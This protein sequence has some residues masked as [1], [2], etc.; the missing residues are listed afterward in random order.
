[1]NLLKIKNRKGDKYFFYY[2][3][4]RGKG[5]RPATGVFIYVKPKDQ[6]EKNHNKEALAL[7]ETKKS[8]LI[9]E[10]QAVGTGHILQHK[11][12]QNFVDFFEE[13][14]RLNRREKNRS[15]PCCLTA[16]NKFLRKEKELKENEHIYLSTIDITENFCERFRQH[17]LDNL[18]G[19]TPGDYFMRF[20]RVMKAAFK[21][22]YFKVNPA[23]EVKTKQHPSGIKDVLT[24]DEYLILIN[25][26]CSNHE[27]KKAAVCSLY[28]GFR[29]CDVGILQWWQIKEETII[30]RKQN[31][32]GV[33]LEVPLP[34]VV[35][36]I[37][38]E[39]K[40]PNDLVFSLPTQDGANKVLKEWVKSAGINKHITWH[41]LRHTVSDLLQSAGVDVQTVASFLGQTTA[42]YI[43][44]TYKKR[45]QA[46]DVIEAGKK[47]P[48]PNIT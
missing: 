45:V 8:Q 11:L 43:L 48:S 6:I 23:A 38:G 29:W 44:Q 28:T 24:V 42:K 5:Q 12:K 33:P 26:Y 31:K 37:I 25:S 14:V 2:D 39:R 35:K 3:L 47:L 13:Y 36:A 1:M 21:Q 18:S 30:L 10:G 4:G 15:L 17:L 20:K 9:L 32:S 27:V 34:P 16:F 46:R 22:G 19:E 41:C 40:N 7:L